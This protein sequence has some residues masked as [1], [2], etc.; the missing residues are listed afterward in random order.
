MPSLLRKSF[1]ALQKN[2][3]SFVTDANSGFTPNSTFP[4]SKLPS[5]RSKS[6]SIVQKSVASG[7]TDAKS[8]ITPNLELPPGS[9][10][11][12]LQNVVVVEQILKRCLLHKSVVS[13]G[14]DVNSGFTPNSTPPPGTPRTDAKITSLWIKSVCLLH[15]SVAARVDG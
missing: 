12:G 7:V 8:G 14:T 10:W 6:C 3:A 11:Y 2:V 1:S 13:R 9:P 15:K 4:D 5:L